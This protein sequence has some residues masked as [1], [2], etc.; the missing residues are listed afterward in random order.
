MQEYELQIEY[1]LGV[2]VGYIPALPGFSVEGASVE[3]A[4]ENAKKALPAFLELPPEEVTHTF[5][6]IKS[7]AK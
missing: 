6:G 1:S 2:F 4:L 3:E 7:I 5:N